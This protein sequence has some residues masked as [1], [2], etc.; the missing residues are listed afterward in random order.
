VTLSFLRRLSVKEKQL[1]S[2]AI[3]A[4]YDSGQILRHFR[5]DDFDCPI[6]SPLAS[7]STSQLQELRA[8]IAHK[9]LEDIL[10]KIFW[11]VPEQ[12]TPIHADSVVSDIPVDLVFNRLHESIM[13]QGAE[14][15]IKN[16]EAVTNPD[17]AHV[18]IFAFD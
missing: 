1:L 6:A 7:L 2:E 12:T 13:Q 15:N 8:L 17:A 5:F 16:S 18:R 4:G 3:I 9:P 11:G 10:A 14:R